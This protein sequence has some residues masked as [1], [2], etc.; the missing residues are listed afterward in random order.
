[1]SNLIKKTTYHPDGF[2]ILVDENNEVPPLECPVC[3]Y[4]MRTSTDFEYWQKYECCEECG[5]KWAEGFYKDKWKL[6]W[7]PEPEDIR[8][9]VER[10]STLVP[11]LNLL[12]GD[13]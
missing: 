8:Q 2:V 9:D 4:F 11:R 5:V 7:R 10:R 3:E 13:N 1:M 6:G 12:L